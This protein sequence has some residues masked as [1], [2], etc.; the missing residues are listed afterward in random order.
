MS[1]ESKWVEMLL[2]TYQIAMILAALEIC[3]KKTLAIASTVEMDKATTF[4]LIGM[5]NGLQ[6]NNCC[7][8]YNI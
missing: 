7:S 8:W 2:E 1:W 6:T 4:N 3:V 5:N